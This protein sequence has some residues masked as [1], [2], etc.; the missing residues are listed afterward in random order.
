VC[1]ATSPVGAAALRSGLP[2]RLF[3]RS[4]ADR[5]VR[6]AQLPVGMATAP[7]IDRAHEAGLQVHVWTVNNR[8]LMGSLLDRGVDGIMTDN[9]ELLREVLIDRGQWHP[10]VDRGEP[11]P[12]T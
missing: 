7:L 2:G 6:C 5:S 1:M 8:D 4:F 11:H 10:R 12:R 3:R 9:T